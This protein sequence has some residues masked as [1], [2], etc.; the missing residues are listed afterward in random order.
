[1][2]WVVFT[3]VLIQEEVS[4][5]KK[6]KLQELHWMSLELIYLLLNHLVL[7]L[8][9]E[10]LLKVKPSHN[11]YLIIGKTLMVT[12]L[13]LEASHKILFS[14]LEREKLLSLQSHPS[15]SSLISF[16]KFVNKIK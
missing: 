3:I 4:L 14:Q 7:L 16:E 10:V 8:T 11:V 1:M 15:M 6:N 9:L 13:K 2:L 12:H 5:M